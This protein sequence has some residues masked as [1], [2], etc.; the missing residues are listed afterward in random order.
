M[1]IG[2]G[3][4]S[5]ECYEN[6]WFYMKYI[7]KYLSAEILLSVVTNWIFLWKKYI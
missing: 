2:K 7:G 5:W 6:K 1:K 4:T 3:M